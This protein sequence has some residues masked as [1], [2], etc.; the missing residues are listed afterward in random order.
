MSHGEIFDLECS[1]R[2]RRHRIDGDRIGEG[3]SEFR[4]RRLGAARP[5]SRSDPA[6]PINVRAHH[7]LDDAA[8]HAEVPAVAQCGLIPAPCVGRASLA[9]ES[10][11]FEEGQLGKDS[12]I[13]ADRQLRFAITFAERNLDR[14]STRRTRPPIN[15]CLF[16]EFEPLLRIRVGFAPTR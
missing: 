15:E 14:L 9:R 7:P 5:S 10:A 8:V 6:E 13:V 12:G 11:G 4:L 3:P 1:R 2:W 16:I